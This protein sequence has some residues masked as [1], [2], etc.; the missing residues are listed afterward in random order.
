M[1]RLLRTYGVLVKNE[2]TARM[3]YRFDFITGI[4]V[5][6][7]SEMLLPIIVLLIYSSGATFPGWRYEEV[8]LIQGVFI[9]STALANTLFFRLVALV[10][11]HVREGTF[12]LFLIKPVPVSLSAIGMSF[13]FE[14]IFVFLGGLALFVYALA[15][16]PSPSALGWLQFILVFILAAVVLLGFTFIL[17]ATA[18]KWVGNSRLFEIFESM[19]QFGRYPVSVYPKVFRAVITYVFPVALLGPIPAAIL[20]RPDSL[21]HLLLAVIF[22][23]VFLS[24]GYLIWRAML[25]SY[26]S[27]GG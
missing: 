6:L 17:A 22:A 9:M 20:M 23:A 7:A 11:E 26:T 4:V 5:S 19:T 10:L 1:K 15:A 12:D 8:L 13:S 25:Q 24:V 27:A 21:T 16:L 18:F 2:L 3:A 14:G